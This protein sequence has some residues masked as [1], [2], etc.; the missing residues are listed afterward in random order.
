MT[1][2]IEILYVMKANRLPN[3]RRPSRRPPPHPP[4]PDRKQRV[5][6]RSLAKLSVVQNNLTLPHTQR[7]MRSLEERPFGPLSNPVEIQHLRVHKSARQRLRSGVIL[8]CPRSTVK[9]AVVATMVED[10]RL[11]AR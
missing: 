3:R 1:T 4:P 7:Y 11:S 10:D 9:K 5:S 6:N 8:M 2:F